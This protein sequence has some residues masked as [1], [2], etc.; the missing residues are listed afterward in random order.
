[1]AQSSSKIWR[2]PRRQATDMPL[3]PRP[4]RPAPAPALGTNPASLG[5]SV[6]ACGGGEETLK[7]QT[8]GPEDFSGFQSHFLGHR[9]DRNVGYN[10][11]FLGQYKRILRDVCQDAFQYGYNLY[12]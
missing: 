8:P 10:P 6:P 4:A 2:I 11:G 12:K 3:V 1:M 7:I 5:S 9:N